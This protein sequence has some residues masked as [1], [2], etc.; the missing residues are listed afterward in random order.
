MIV[1]FHVHCFND[2]LANKA[3][4]TLSQRAGIRLSENHA[5]Y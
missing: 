1:D 5:L 2:E 4:N 3:V